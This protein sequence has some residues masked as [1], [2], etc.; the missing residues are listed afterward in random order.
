MA[1][2]YRGGVMKDLLSQ[3]LI[4]LLG[5]AKGFLLWFYDGRQPITEAAIDAGVPS[6]LIK[7]KA[8]VP[9]GDGDYGI[10]WA[11]YVPGSYKIKRDAAQTVNGVGLKTGLATWG[12]I[13]RWDDDPTL[14][15]T[16]KP[17]E[18]FS[19]GSLPGA[20]VQLGDIKITLGETVPFN[21]ENFGLSIT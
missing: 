1:K 12:M 3:D 4:D 15:T 21:D 20:D 8:Y 5:G 16:T 18:T 9:D 6:P 13:T 11:E 19:V 14:P 17:R 10:R 7:F 2:I